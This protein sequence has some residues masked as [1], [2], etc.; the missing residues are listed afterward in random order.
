M[1]R[2]GFSTGALAF[3]DFQK[4]IELLHNSKT[5]AIEL[6]ALRRDELDPLV[7]LVHELDLSRY[8][9]ISVHAPSS[10]AIDDEEHVIKLLETF[11][12]RNWPIIVHPDAIKTFERWRV[13]GKLLLIENMDRK[14]TRLNSSHQL[15][16]Y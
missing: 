13:F 15:I 7:S 16:S 2:I 1:R 14:S 12:R 6:S 5:N 8:A 11:A 3:G 4:A 10:F 9:Y